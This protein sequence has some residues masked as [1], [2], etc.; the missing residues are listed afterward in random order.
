MTF[1]KGMTLEN[2]VKFQ[3]HQVPGFMADWYLAM[4]YTQPSLTGSP[5]DVRYFISIDID[6]SIVQDRSDLVDD[7]CGD[8]REQLGTAHLRNV[9]WSAPAS[10]HGCR[11]AIYIKSPCPIYKLEYIFH[12]DKE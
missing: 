10:G 4:I 11:A 9:N 2:Y 1:Y 8:W 7:M 6:L 5:N 12:G 3:H